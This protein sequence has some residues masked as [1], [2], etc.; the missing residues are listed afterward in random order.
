MGKRRG[1]GEGSISQR[2]DG[3]WQA[4]I[5]IGYVDGKRKRKSIYGETRKEVAEQLKVLLHEQQQGLPIA[6]ERQ[7]VGQFL[8]RWLKES[9]EPRRR[10]NTV[11]G[12]SNIVRLHL[13]PQIGHI[14]LAKLTPQHVEQL[15]NRM[16]EK[17]K[18]LAERTILLIRTVL[19]RALQQALKW[20]LVA[21][22]VAA[23][24]DAPTVE[25][26]VTTP[27]TPE[28]A[29]EFLQTIRGERHA[30][31]F[32][33]TLWLGLRRGEV[34]GLRWEDIDFDEQ[35][36]HVRMAQVVVKGK[37]LLAQPKT[38]NSRRRLTIPPSLLSVLREHKRHQA[39]EQWKAG[40]KWQAHGLVFCTTK[41]T[42]FN[43]RNITRDFKDFM[44]QEGLPN[45]RFHDLRHSCASLLCHQK[46]PARVMMDILGHSTIAT[47]LNIYAHVF[48]EAKREAAD[49]MERLLGDKREAA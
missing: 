19:R 44:K 22:N 3:R 32:A 35:K 33:T 42:P 15:M 13:K 18:N 26:F 45:I 48:D 9:V 2:A 36:L 25:E 39:E 10:H 12:Y 6:M 16:R 5:N 11:A 7:T 4:R 38:K 1:H 30:A 37:I 34:L 20:G 27:L 47:T 21:R 17:D 46:V 23:L 29:G 28:R 24:T 14:Q 49:A 40:K 8:D 31:L 43:P 41:G